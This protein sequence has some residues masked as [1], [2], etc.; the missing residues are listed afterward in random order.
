VFVISDMYTSVNEN[1]NEGSL[2]HLSSY[3]SSFMNISFSLVIIAKR[4]SNTRIW[5]R[6]MNFGTGSEYWFHYKSLR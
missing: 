4:V 3:S 1:N 5:N 2:V 6:V